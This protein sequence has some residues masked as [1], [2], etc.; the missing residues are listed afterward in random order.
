MNEAFNFKLKK[1]LHVGENWKIWQQRRFH[2][3]IPHAS[4]L[5]HKK[6]HKRNFSGFNI[7]EFVPA[8]VPTLYKLTHRNLIKTR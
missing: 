2:Y 6:F 7:I 4:K 1:L 8:K 5:L 3:L